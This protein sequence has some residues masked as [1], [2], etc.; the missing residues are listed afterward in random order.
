MG[1]ACDARG[2]T[3][4]VARNGIR[5]GARSDA[6]NIAR[7]IAPSDIRIRARCSPQTRTQHIVHHRHR[8]TGHSG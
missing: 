8:R 6:G 5:S 1:G 2:A 4:D 3:R 7:N